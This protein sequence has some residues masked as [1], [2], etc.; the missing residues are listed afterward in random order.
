[1]PR[2]LGALSSP[3]SRLRD[4]EMM[5]HLPFCFSDTCRETQQVRHKGMWAYVS[6]F[7]LGS[8]SRELWFT[9]LAPRQG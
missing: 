6:K 7:W 2:I 3:S 4:I 9:T 1:M 8:V 5:P